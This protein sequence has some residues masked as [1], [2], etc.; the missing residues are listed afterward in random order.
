MHAEHPFT[1]QENPCDSLTHRLGC[2]LI[3]RAILGCTEFHDLFSAL[4]RSCSIP[5]GT[6]RL[7]HVVLQMQTVFRGDYDK[8]FRINT[9][10]I[11]MDPVNNTLSFHQNVLLEQKHRDTL[12][13]HSDWKLSRLHPSSLE[14]NS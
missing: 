5:T 7:N 14:T 13:Q 2:P 11:F 8:G 9:S 10:E 1:Q 3:G 6:L 4:P 12:E